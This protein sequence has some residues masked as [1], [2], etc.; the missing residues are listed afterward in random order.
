MSIIEDG[1]GG[2]K[3]ALDP[4]P[5]IPPWTPVHPPHPDIPHFF[6]LKHASSGVEK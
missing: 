6:T 4:C 2:E 3:C 5:F 1:F